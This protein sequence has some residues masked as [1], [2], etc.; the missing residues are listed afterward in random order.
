[1]A[2]AKIGDLD[3]CCERPQLPP[4]VASKR[5]DSGTLLA[6]HQGHVV[7]RPRRLRKERGST[8]A[9][10]A[11]IPQAALTASRPIN[12]HGEERRHTIRISSISLQV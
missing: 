6:A 9:V 1:M 2:K 5:S 8:P 4:A 3:K 11:S 10:L 7:H 12:Q